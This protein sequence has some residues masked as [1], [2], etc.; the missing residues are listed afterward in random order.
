MTTDIDLAKQH[1]IDYYLTPENTT[2]MHGTDRQVQAFADVVRL[3]E[4]ERIAESQAELARLR[5]EVDE[6]REA[7]LVASRAISEAKHCEMYDVRA[8][9]PARW[10]LGCCLVEDRFRDDGW[11]STQELAEFLRELAAGGN[12]QPE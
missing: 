7:L 5:A 4:R 10:Q 11:C 8:R 9:P 1:G 6:L 12:A 2:E 3:S